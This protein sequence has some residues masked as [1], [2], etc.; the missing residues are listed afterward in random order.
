MIYP[1]VVW[2][3]LCTS[4]HAVTLRKKFIDLKTGRTLLGSVMNIRAR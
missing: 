1:I 2:F 3:V 4:M